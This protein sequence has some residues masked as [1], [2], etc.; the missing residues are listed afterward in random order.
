MGFFNTDFF[1]YLV[2]TGGHLLPGAIASLENSGLALPGGLS[3]VAPQ[4]P[5]MSALN[6]L[7]PTDLTGR[8]IFVDAVKPSAASLNVILIIFS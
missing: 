4:I 8:G 5:V 2:G 1:F 7:T 3:G 6:G